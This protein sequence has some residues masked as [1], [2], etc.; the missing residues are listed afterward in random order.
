G[1]MVNDIVVDPENPS[2]IFAG[3]R[4]GVCRSDNGGDDWELLSFSRNRVTAALGISSQAFYAGT[5]HSQL[6]ECAEDSKLH[7]SYDNGESWVL[8][9]DLDSLWI[10]SITLLGGDTILVGTFSGTIRPTKMSDFE[11]EGGVFLSQDGGESWEE[12]NGNLPV[13]QVFDLTVDAENAIYVILPSPDGVWQSNDL[14]AT[15]TPKNEGLVEEENYYQLYVNPHDGKT[16]FLTAGRAM[17]LESAAGIWRFN[18]NE[19][20]WERLTR[21]GEPDDNVEKPWNYEWVNADANE[22]VIDPVNPDRIFY[23]GRTIHRSDDGGETWVGDAFQENNGW[24]SNTGHSEHFA[25]YIRRHPTEENILFYGDQD[26]RIGRSIDGG[27]SWQMTASD[28]P[29]GINASRDMVFDVENNVIYAAVGSKGSGRGKVIKS[30]D[31]GVSWVDANTGL[32]D[33]FI[34]R[35]AIDLNTPRD[36]R[37]LYALCTNEG[38]YKSEDGANSWD[39]LDNA[40]PPPGGNLDYIDIDLHPTNEGVIYL[41][42]YG[43][44]GGL[45]VGTEYGHNWEKLNQ[46]G[47]KGFVDLVIKPDEPNIMMAVGKVEDGL[48][49]SEDGGV[50]WEKVYEFHEINMGVINSAIAFDPSHTNIVYAGASSYAKAQASGEPFRNWFLRSEDGGQ[51]WEDMD[52]PIGGGMSRITFIEVQPTGE[53]FVGTSGYGGYIYYPTIMNGEPDISILPPEIN[54]FVE[55][56]HSTTSSFT[57]SNNGEGVLSFSIQTDLG[58]TS[59]NVSG[60]SENFFSSNRNSIIKNQRENQSKNVLPTL[61]SQENISS[62]DSETTK[63]L[64]WM[65]VDPA[66]GIVNP[67]GNQE[68]T[69]YFDASELEM[70]YYSGNL[71]VTSN[72]PD[73][74]QS[75]LPVQLAVSERGDVNFDGL[76]DVLDVVRVI[77]IILEIEP[78][79]TEYELWA[80]DCNDDGDINIL[81]I[82]GIVNVILGTGSCGG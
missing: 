71:I 68:V 16:L 79:P 21:I 1:D 72:D 69:I 45:Y 12:V 51:T 73:Q 4:R 2:R 82:I 67:G 26:W 81:D 60:Y 80:A 37:I 78:S 48:Y 53:I 49:R 54:S 55:I 5:A 56:G 24:W 52:S 75:T 70:G 8:L 31:N 66:S 50:S 39:K 63:P 23:I 10:S 11:T 20:M 58:D 33:A 64:Y 28:L 19:D 46:N 74:S 18:E 36:Q 62:E 65:Y 6:K 41:S 61:R 77:N 32:P 57:I 7:V 27:I 34:R 15:W 35:I 13:K 43:W 38:V 44:P 17:A 47:P 9:K 30:D 14:G 22:M 59:I 40:P 76:K 42:L 3:T 29:W 25:Y